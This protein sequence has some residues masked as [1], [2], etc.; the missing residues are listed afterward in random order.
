MKLKSTAI[1]LSATM[2]FSATAFAGSTGL[3]RDH[4]HQG[5]AYA[6]MNDFNSAI[7]EFKASI[8][9]KPTSVA[10]SNLGATYMQIGKHNLALKA[11]KKAE[12]LNRWDN[13]VM[14]NMAANYSLSDDT[15]LALEYLDKALQ[16]GFSNYDAIR[17]DPDLSN[18][19]G[20]PE[21]RTVL[22]RNKVFIQ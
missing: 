15:D 1:L 22:E 8:S 3:A 2:V 4:V 16:R 18:L 13:V 20:E 19:R 5:M 7:Q 9:A 21:F 6:N 10:Y 11:L 14:Y 17:F 12:A